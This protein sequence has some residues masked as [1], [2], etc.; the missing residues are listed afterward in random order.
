[1]PLLHQNPFLP[2]IRA[3]A[4]ELLAYTILK[5]FPSALCAGGGKTD[6]GFFYDI[7]FEQPLDKQLID[8]IE[9]EMKNHIKEDLEIRSLSMMRENA[10]QLLLHH[11]Q[12]ILADKAL[13][14]ELNIISICQIGSFHGLSTESHVTTTKEIGFIKILETQELEDQ[15]VRFIGTA[16]RD[17][18]QLKQFAKAYE[19]LKKFDHRQLGQ[20]LKFFTLIDENYFWLPKGEWLRKFLEAIWE[21]EC[22]KLSMQLISTP[23]EEPRLAQHIQLFNT[24]NIKS[25][26]LPIR[27]GEVATIQADLK[28]QEFWGLFRSSL[29]QSD[30]VT[31]FCNENQVAQEIIYS[32]QF[33]E[34]IVKIIGFEA[35][36]YLISSVGK[37]KNQLEE[38]LSSLGITYLAVNGEGNPRIEVKWVDALGREWNGPSIEIVALKAFVEVIATTVFGSIERIVGLMIEHWKGDLPLR[39]APEQVRVLQVGTSSAE[40]AQQVYKKCRERG[41]RA[42][43]DGTEEKLAQKIH[44]AEKEHVPYLV[45]VGDKEASHNKVTVRQFQ[46]KDQTNLLNLNDFFEE[47]EKT[48]SLEEKILEGV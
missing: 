25:D 32:L 16:F 26:S 2:I 29:Y 1:M 30:L 19:K 42:S 28:E 38:A 6:I 10:H 46:G 11:G 44:R 33:I 41:F 35:Q 22:Q 36:W 40:Y 23:F 8:L 18:Y 34:Q 31:T 48:F 21:K 24:Q 17:T 37:K 39:I 12:P 15:I 7:I 13:E 9:M 20:D 5:I 43:L 3:S 47:V 27:Y 4:A 45:I 14:E